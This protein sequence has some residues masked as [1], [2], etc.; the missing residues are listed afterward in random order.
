MESA[1]AFNAAVFG[2][3]AAGQMLCPRCR[4]PLSPFSFPHTPEVGLDVCRQCKGIWLDDGEMQKIAERVDAARQ[5]ARPSPRPRAT[6]EQTRAVV[7]FLLSAP[8]PSCQ[9][10]NP[11]SAL[12]CWACGQTIKT[13]SLLRLCPKCDRAMDS[14]VFG[15]QTSVETCL[16]SGAD[17]FE[18]G[19]L[20]VFF[21]LGPAVIKDVGSRIAS[22]SSNR[23]QDLI[24][25]NLKCPGCH[26][27][28]EC[29]AFGA[30]TAMKI[31]TCTYCSSDWLDPGELPAAYEYMPGA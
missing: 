5:K 19:E 3:G 9:T 29:R 6:T 17:W 4:Q 31:E 22:S 7:G 13:R 1:R 15:Q 2:G 28:M 26:Y 18:A 14:T 30:A 11:A 24:Q 23:N 12:S 21:Q 27:S 25:R 8:C 10:T 20:S 16:A